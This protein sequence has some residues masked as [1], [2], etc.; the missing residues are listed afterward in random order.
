[1]D[2]NKYFDEVQ[3]YVKQNIEMSAESDAIIN[4]LKSD[5][6]Q[7]VVNQDFNDKVSIEEC[8]EKIIKQLEIK[9][10]N[11]DVELTEPNAIAGERGMNTMEKNVLDFADF[12]KY[13]L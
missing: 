6:I 10:K 3:N 11:S 13:K 8:G 5:N 4:S 12:K 9:Q 1:M 7:A 2:I